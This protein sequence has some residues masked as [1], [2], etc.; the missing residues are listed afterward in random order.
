MTLDQMLDQYELSLPKPSTPGGNYSSVNV[1]GKIAYVAIQFPIRD[2]EYYYQGILGKTLN[3]NDGY[4]AMQ[5]CALNVIAQIE[6][7]IGFEKVLGL[8]HIDA[9]YVADESWD[10]AP[11]VVN[12]ASDTFVNLLNDK[13]THSRAIIG[14]QALPRQFYVGLT[15]TFTLL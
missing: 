2:E 14:V 4:A 5:L 6:A 8:N 7:K 9:Y 10:E 15:A 11:K 12:G 13:G 3:T 1:R